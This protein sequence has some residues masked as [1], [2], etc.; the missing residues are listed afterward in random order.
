MVQGSEGAEVL[1][2]REVHFKSLVISK[3]VWRFL[4]L[5]KIFEIN[6]HTP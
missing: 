3:I 6:V 2:C 5:V 1:P 4:E